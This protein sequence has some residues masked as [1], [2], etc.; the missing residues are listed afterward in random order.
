MSRQTPIGL[1][2]KQLDKA[3]TAYTDEALARYGVTRLHWQTLNLIKDA[4]HI[5]FEKLFEIMKVFLE[6]DQLD[7]VVND[8]TQRNWVRREDSSSFSITNE[9]KR[10]FAEL[11]KTQDGV[12]MVVM[13]GISQSD[14]STVISILQRMIDNLSR[15]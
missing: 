14:Y 11:A 15:V 3:L 7:A 2:I 4:D 10:G 9:G 6:K 5:T 8:L 1:I 13:K 12:R